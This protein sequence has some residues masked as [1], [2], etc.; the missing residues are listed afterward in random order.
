MP[1]L[2][3]KE[4]FRSRPKVER[5]PNEPENP[6]AGNYA[7]HAN[8]PP[9]EDDADIIEGVIEETT[10]PPPYVPPAS[11]IPHEPIALPEDE[12]PS[13]AVRQPR[14]KVVRPG[15]LLIALGLII[16]GVFVT[17]LNTVTLPDSV[18]RWYPMGSLGVA[19][20]WAFVALV[21]RNIAQFVAGMVVFG[22]SLSLLLD[23]QDVA[24][25]RETFIGILLM[26]F[27][28]AIVIRGL[29]LRQTRLV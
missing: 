25:F 21:R 6:S 24:S 5:Q 15:L 19:F 8:T 14:L 3:Q 10:P 12:P 2:S 22:L 18:L 11:I 17:L 9:I 27:G 4:P 7:G 29:L 1:P 28:L 20:G 26:S 16:G 23:T 13:R